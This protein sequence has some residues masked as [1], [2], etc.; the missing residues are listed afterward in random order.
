MFGNVAFKMK[1]QWKLALIVAF[2]TTITIVL[3]TYIVSSRLVA[4]YKAEAK[5]D[6]HHKAL[7]IRHGLL[8]VMI[9]TNDYEKIDQAIQS[10]SREQDFKLKMIRSEHVIKQHGVRRNEIPEDEHERKALQTGETIELFKGDSYRV[11]YPFV[12]DKRC[13][14]CHVGLDGEPVPA[15]VV[16]GLA[17][18]TFDLSLMKADTNTLIN[19]ITISLAVV[20]TIAGLSLLAMA[21]VTV[22]NPVKSI[23]NAITGFTEDRFDVNLPDYDTREIGIMA[24]QVRSAAQKLSE[25]KAHRENEINLERSRSEDIKKFVLSK[26]GELGLSGDVELS[27]VITKLSR[28]VDESDRAAQMA[29]ALEFIVQKETRME[30]PNDASLIPCISVYL[31]YVT[32]ADILRRRS[33]ELVLEEALA[34]AV[35]HGNLEVPS[36]LKEDDFESFNNLIATRISLEPYA[37]RK[38]RVLYSFNRKSAVFVIKDEGAGFDWRRTIAQECDTEAGHGRGLL[39]M[40]ALATEINFSDKG[41]EVTLTFDLGKSGS[42]SAEA[43]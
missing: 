39:L 16:N 26:A 20:M 25:M 42:N 15:G 38:T 22:I 33:I 43:V 2:F 41:D 8:S 32:T 13:G 7:L 19:Y 36:H 23:A 5:K 10:L 28:V 17:S 14:A 6:A 9:E 12:T 29:R 27:Q 31:A 34:N 1:L 4:N 30:I 35:I 11:I 37:S 40:Q 24:A 21:H 3:I 18:L